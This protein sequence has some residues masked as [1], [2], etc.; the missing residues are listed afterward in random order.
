MEVSLKSLSID[1]LPDDL[2]NLNQLS[3]DE[4]PEYN[5][6]ISNIY[7]INQFLDNIIIS[8][9]TPKFEKLLE[10]L[11]R[12][13]LIYLEKISFDPSIYRNCKNYPDFNDQQIQHLLESKNHIDNANII[14]SSISPNKKL[15]NIRNLYN[16]LR[17]CKNAY[18]LI[19]LI[20]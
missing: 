8:K 7:Q 20:I 12:Q 3:I 19:L 16:A 10:N 1:N 2:P 9:V 17:S 4:N 14:L 13:N 6:L 18:E 11:Y 15:W 5:K